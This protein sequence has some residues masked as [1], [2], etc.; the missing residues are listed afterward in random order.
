MDSSKKSMFK[1]TMLI[2]IIGGSVWGLSEVALN[3]AIRNAGLPLRA[4]I[5]TGIA[6]LI[7]GVLGGYF[8]KA[9]YIL[10]AVIPAVI[11]VQ[12]GVVLCGAAVSC[13]ANTCV[14][15]GL[16]AGMASLVFKASG[17]GKRKMNWARVALYGSA[18]AFSSAIAFYFIGMRCAPCPYLL[19]FNS[20]AG[21][22]SYLTAEALPWTVLGGAGFSLGNILGKKAAESWAF[23]PAH[24]GMAHYMTGITV[25]VLCWILSAA[26][27][28]I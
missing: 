3:S 13:K 2:L 5:L 6:F 28:M 15:L 21:F 22:V 12:M 18:A 26:I 16:H 1:N 10:P 9:W 25:A 7:I 14:A 19:S 8:K 20:S 24:A 11:I 17:M 23:V 27:I 4:G